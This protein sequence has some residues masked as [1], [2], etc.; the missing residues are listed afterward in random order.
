MRRCLVVAHQT[1][2][3]PRLFEALRDRLSAAPT[4]FHLVVPE[5]HGDGFVWDEGKV[6]L[7][8]EQHLQEALLR[9]L[10][11]G[12]AVSG[13]VG[14]TDPVTAVQNVLAREG[15]TAFDEIIVST[16]PAR[17]SKWLGV[18]APTRIARL[19]KVPVT[20]LEAVTSPAS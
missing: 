17:F 16:L 19:A 20:H 8:A 2:D 10:A 12:L 5:Y 11:D 3:S 1:L 7:Q 14:V 15:D 6:R 4:A 13:E 18:D 9:F